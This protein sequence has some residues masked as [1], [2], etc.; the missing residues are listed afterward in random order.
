MADDPTRIISANDMHVI[1]SQFLSAA[2]SIHIA[3]CRFDDDHAAQEFLGDALSSVLIGAEQC[4]KLHA[5][6]KHRLRVPTQE[7]D[8]P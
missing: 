5:S 3:M 6:K 7:N 1:T 8:H 2:K 4:Q